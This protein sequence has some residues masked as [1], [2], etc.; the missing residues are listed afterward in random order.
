MLESVNV[1]GAYCH[2]IDVDTK[3]MCCS[4]WMNRDR[5]A[6]MIVTVCEN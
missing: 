4:T 6:L 1:V 2:I 3:P 5:Q